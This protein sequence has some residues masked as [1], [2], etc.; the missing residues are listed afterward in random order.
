MRIRDID[1]ATKMSE[2]YQDR[3]GAVRT[4]L[5]ETTL[6][7]NTS[8][9]YHEAGPDSTADTPTPRGAHKSKAAYRLKRLL[10]A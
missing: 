4:Q 7:T 1:I 8:L 10:K 9:S 3:R 6:L 5:E 2:T